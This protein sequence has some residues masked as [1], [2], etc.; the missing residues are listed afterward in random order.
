LAGGTSICLTGSR[1]DQGSAATN[2]KAKSRWFNETT[3]P[4]YKHVEQIFHAGL[5][6]TKDIKDLNFAAPH[7]TPLPS[8]IDK[9]GQTYLHMFAVCSSTDLQI[10]WAYTA[11]SYPRLSLVVVTVP[12][13]GSGHSLGKVNYRLS[14]HVSCKPL[15]YFAFLFLTGIG[16]CCIAA[17][18][19]SIPAF[20]RF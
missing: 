13:L 20:P 5:A 7:P 9:Q 14:I 3:R 16:C 12:A 10:P 19:C 2:W 4:T 17:S 18:A 6:G 15:P 11:M 1:K 8:D